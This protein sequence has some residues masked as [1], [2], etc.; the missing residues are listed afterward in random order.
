MM[1][2]MAVQ[3][4][5]RKIETR[6]QLGIE[7]SNYIM[8]VT[9]QNWQNLWKFVCCCVFTLHFIHT[10]S[11]FQK[12]VLFMAHVYT[13]RTNEKWCII[14]SNVSTF[15][16]LLLFYFSV[17]LFFSSFSSPSFPSTYSHLLYVCMCCLVMNDISKA[18]E[19]NFINFSM[20]TNDASSTH[21]HIAIRCHQIV[22]VMY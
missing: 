14:H 21:L 18:L 4:T 22:P 1:I 19:G 8:L 20:H 12:C 17:V 7:F 6:T 9:L 15:L 11:T 10:H 16:L 13:L 2:M 5:V 3:M